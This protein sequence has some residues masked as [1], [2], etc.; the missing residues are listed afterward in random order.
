MISLSDLPIENRRKKIHHIL[1]CPFQQLKSKKNIF[2][3]FI[4]IFLLYFFCIF[5]S[6]WP[7]KWNYINVSKLNFIKW[8]TVVINSALNKSLFQKIG[9]F[10]N[11][12]NDFIEKKFYLHTQQTF[13][14]LHPHA[15]ATINKM[16]FLRNTKTI[17]LARC[18]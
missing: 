18:W 6:L 7:F 12:L 9:K 14:V 3:F 1:K 4:V 10:P 5:G 17:R 2:A 8:S 13:L 11:E 15:P 16:C